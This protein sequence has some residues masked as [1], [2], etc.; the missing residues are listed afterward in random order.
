M[1]KPRAHNFATWKFP[2]FSTLPFLRRSR[3]RGRHDHVISHVRKKSSSPPKTQHTHTHIRVENW[4]K[5]AKQVPPPRERTE[6]EATR[7]RERVCCVRQQKCCKARVA[8]NKWSVSWLVS[9]LIVLKF[10]ARAT[11]SRAGAPAERSRSLRARERG[12]T[13]GS[14]SVS[15]DTGGV[16]P[17]RGASAARRHLAGI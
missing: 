2:F 11:A 17:G 13:L 9:L 10:E 1:F 15:R 16:T 14:P 12:A 4:R 5:S 7:E 6:T 8:R 3:G